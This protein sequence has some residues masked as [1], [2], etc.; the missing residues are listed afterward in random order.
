MREKSV[1]VIEVLMPLNFIL[2]CKK[3]QTW[4]ELSIQIDCDISSNNIHAL[5]GAC[6]STVVLAGQELTPKFLS[7]IQNVVIYLVKG[8]RL[9]DTCNFNRGYN[10][11]K[12]FKI[13]VQ[14]WV[15]TSKALFGIWSKKAFYISN[16]TRR[17]TIQ[18][19]G[20]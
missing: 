17:Q 6:Y 9:S 11:G 2:F 1:M 15:A 4:P 12:H 20:S 16:L 18:D 3:L 19:L 14:I 10:F 7:S 8:F 13:L 5:L